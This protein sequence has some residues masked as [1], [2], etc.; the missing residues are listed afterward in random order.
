[1][2]NEPIINT[3]TEPGVYIYNDQHNKDRRMEVRLCKYDGQLRIEGG[4]GPWV[5]CFQG[6][7]EK[8]GE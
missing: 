1:M 4:R 6:T 8:V 7:W 2:K 5:G 3:P